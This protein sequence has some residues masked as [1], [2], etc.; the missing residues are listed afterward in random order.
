MLKFP[1]KLHGH[2]QLD[3]YT[4]AAQFPPVSI[5]G[6]WPKQDPTM[7]THIHI[8]PVFPYGAEIGAEVFEV[9]FTLKAF[10]LDGHIGLFESECMV[11]I[12][13]N[14]TGTSTP[15]TME[16]DP[17]SM[18]PK[19]WSGVMTVDTTKGR[20]R[21]EHGWRGFDFM[22]RTGFNNG[23]GPLDVKGFLPMFS[24]L[25]LTKDEVPPPGNFGPILSSRVDVSSMTGEKFGT[26]V[27]E[28]ENWIPLLPI[29]NK[30]ITGLSAYD[31]A[32]GTNDSLPNGR[33]EQR[34]NL[35]L[36]NGV[37]GLL[38]DSLNADKQGLSNKPIVFDPAVMNPGVNTIAEFWTQN[39][40][41]KTVSALVV[42]KVNAASGTG[43]MTSIVP[44]LTGKSRSQ[45]IADLNAVGLL[46]GTESSSSD[47][48]IPAGQVASQFPHATVVVLTG[49]TVNIVISTGGVVIPAEQW[50]PAIPTFM[51][52]HINGVPQKRWQICGVDD[53]MTM[54]DCIE[55][56]TKPEPMNMMSMD[57]GSSDVHKM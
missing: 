52:L 50:I 37:R 31:Y 54:D 38:T 42:I 27:C 55:L 44:D 41:G 51:Q 14:D 25:D 22:A 28:I 24:V 21:V 56:E 26:M 2:P 46:L 34:Q 30:W 15:P 23:D 4:S 57:N 53:S 9:P 11:D 48:T 19:T 29:S 1:L 40:N 36:H 12:K 13:W 3:F 20:F 35:D 7:T 6:H 8:D 5:Q 43:V 32:T 18:I 16:G 39:L 17:N 47:Q 45:A 33:F 10:M 49:S